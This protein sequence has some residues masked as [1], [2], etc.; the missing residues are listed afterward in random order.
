MAGVGIG[1]MIAAIGGILYALIAVK[2]VFFGES[3]DFD[4][5][6]EGMHGVPQGVVK[7]PNQVHERTAETDAVH[8]KGAPGTVV[9]VGIFLLVFVLYYFTNWK[10]LSLVWKIG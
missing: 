2:S 6:Q 7:L 1:G 10:L 8:K 3:I 9:L 4:N 5:M